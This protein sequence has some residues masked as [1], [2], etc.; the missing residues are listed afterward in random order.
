MTQLRPVESHS[1]GQGTVLHVVASAGLYGLERMLIGLLPA[2]RALGC[3]ATLASMG[4]P[5]T[6]GGALG[7]AL[8]SL[9]VPVCYPVFTGRFSVRGVARLEATLRKTRPALV[10]LHGYKAIILGGPISLAKRIPTVATFHTEVMKTTGFATHVAIEKHVVRR[11]HGLV[12]VS[13]PI[14]KELEDRGV[15][16]SRIRVIANGI[17]DPGPQVDSERQRR[18]E[19]ADPVLVFT[20]RLVEGKNVHLLL[21]AVHHLRGEF[22][23]TRLLIA[24]D[25]PLRPALEAQAD[26]L[27]I[28]ESV[29]F[30]GFVDDVYSLL[31]GATCF[32]LPSRAEGMPIALLEAMALSVP[33]VATTVGSI[34]HIVSDGAEALL[35]EPDDLPALL[36]ALRRLLRDQRLRTRLGERARATFTRAFTA[37]KAASRYREFYASVLAER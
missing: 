30:L 36:E 20:G 2:L 35:V 22:P 27:G 32:V 18:T 10:H 5:G 9:G 14:R 12:A 33:I 16:A 8:S 28:S 7:K 24:G 4:A 17:T 1:A 11:L 6:P 25:G 29:R 34:P 21:E 19:P 31:T 3:D 37:E 23:G 13:E 26:S 15:P